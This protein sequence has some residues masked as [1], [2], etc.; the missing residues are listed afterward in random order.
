MTRNYVRLQTSDEAGVIGK[1]GSCFGAEAISIRSIVQ[2]EGQ[3][4]QAE[5]VVLTHEV[6]EDRFRAALAAIAALTE[7]KTIAASLRTL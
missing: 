1:I 2:F 6:P 7:V 4:G 3:E 5:I